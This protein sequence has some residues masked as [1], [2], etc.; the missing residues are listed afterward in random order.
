MLGAMGRIAVVCGMLGALAAGVVRA[1]E[2]Q[3]MRLIQELPQQVRENLVARPERFG[4]GM[5]RVIGDFG[6]AAGIDR[7]GIALFIGVTRAKARSTATASLMDADL[8]D[9]GVIR[10]SEVE[11]LGQTV[12]AARRGQMRRQFDRADADR[13]QQVTAAELRADAAAAANT[14][15]DGAQELALR[16]LPL[17]DLDKDGLVSVAEVLQVAAVAQAA[18]ATMA[19]QAALAAKTEL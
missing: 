5:A 19:E 14:A 11:G 12:S 8:D 6:S 16:S 3:I 7:A 9:D 17:L 18:A 4:T 1:D 2:Q 13:D 15:I 10:R